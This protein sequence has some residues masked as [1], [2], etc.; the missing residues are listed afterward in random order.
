M[1]RF[2]GIAKSLS[3]FATL[4]LATVATGCGGGGDPILGQ[5]GIGALAPVNLG[6]LA[7]FGI[8][9]F[10]GMTN[11][12]PTKING[13]VVLDTDQTCQGTGAA[14]AVGNTN[15][16]GSSC[17]AT[18]GANQVFNNTGDTVITQIWNG[19]SADTTT[20]DAVMATLLT[21]WNSI[22]PAGLPGA[23]VL[24]CGTIG[25]AGGAGALIGCSGNA[26]LPPGAY[27]SASNSTID[28]SGDLTLNGGASDVWVFQAP[29]AL[30]AAPASRILLTGG[31]RASNVWWFVGSSATLN[32]NTEFQGS[33]LASASISL[34][35]LATSCGRL[36]AGAE[37]AGAFTFL[38]NT[39]S[40]PGHPN[41]PGVCL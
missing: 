41:A 3:W 13:N 37:G 24:G 28:I 14:V 9:S 39:V 5:G 34:G 29:S 33:I 26:T 19:V 30:T 18:A 32:N 8:A 36:L 6:I 2:S 1:N 23:T 15:D 38:S 16:F 22:S 20:A 4:L 11:S 7:P 35:T 10:G 25:S 40:V 21:K 12:G 31:A 17:N 27:I